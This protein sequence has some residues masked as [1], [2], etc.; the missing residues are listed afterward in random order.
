MRDT[1]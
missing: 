1:F